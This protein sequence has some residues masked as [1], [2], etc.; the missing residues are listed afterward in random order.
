[1]T[2]YITHQ[3]GRLR[4][5]KDNLAVYGQIASYL[6]STDTGHADYTSSICSV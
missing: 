1:M 5:F 4:T 2:P 6:S 3:E